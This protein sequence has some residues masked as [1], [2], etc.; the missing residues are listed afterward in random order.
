MG[1]FARWHVLRHLRHREQA[2]VATHGA[3]SAVRAS[4]VATSRFL[5]WLAEHKP[6]IT[7][8]TQVDLDQYAVE[9]SGQ[10]RAVVAFLA[11]TARTGLT[12]DLKLPTEQSAQAEVTLADEDRW[13][14]A[15]LLLHDDTIRLYVR[16]AGLFTLLFAQPLARITRMRA[17]QVTVCDDGRV[18]VTFDTVPIELPESLGRLVLAH[19]ARRG[20]ASHASRPDR[21]AL[22]VEGARPAGCDETK[23][24]ALAPIDVLFEL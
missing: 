7:T 23:Y 3:I 4:I 21:W 22:L 10:A 17:E 14:P 13:A 16:V 24:P 9:H 18:T 1:G 11:W 6:S 20:Q 15:Q 5:A 12:S 2:R 19:L 8:A